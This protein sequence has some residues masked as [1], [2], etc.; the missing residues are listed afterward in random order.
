M[1]APIQDARLSQGDIVQNVVFSYIPDIS[2]PALYLNGE[3]VERDLTRPFDPQEELTLLAEA[4]KSTVLVIEPDCNIDHKDYVSVA[5]IFP[6]E[7]QDAAFR[8]MTNAER[9]AKYLRR[10]Y[11]DVGVQPNVYYLQ[12][13]PNHGFPK[14]LAFLLELH[15]IRR[16][17]RNMEFMVRN[18]ILRLSAEAIG[19]LQYRIGFFFGRYTV[20]TDDYMLTEAERVLVRPPAETRPE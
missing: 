4:H 16:S 11:Q 19:D 12:E 5:R 10:Q 3:P 2:D 9:R 17:G 1:Y 15:T 8:G 7:E 14:S 20:T 6:L 13:S 18:R